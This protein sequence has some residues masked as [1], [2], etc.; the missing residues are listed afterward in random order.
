[1]YYRH[2]LQWSVDQNASYGPLS[3]KEK[4]KELKSSHEARHLIFQLSKDK[5]ALIQ[6]NILC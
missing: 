5:G 6:G 2:Q 3:K 1:M 4:K